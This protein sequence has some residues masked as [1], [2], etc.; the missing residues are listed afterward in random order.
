MHSNLWQLQDA[1]SKFSELVDQALSR[2]AQ[3]ITKRG[4]KAVVIIPFDEY[5]QLTRPENDNLSQ[6]LLNSPLVGSQLELN[7]IHDYPR[8][9][10]IE[11]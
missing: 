9:I 5:V 3:I 11:S 1:K 7:R 4:K 10:E 2:G 6:F 8:N